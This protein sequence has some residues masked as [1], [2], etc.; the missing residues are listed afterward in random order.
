MILQHIWVNRLQFCPQLQEYQEL[1][2]KIKLTPRLWNPEIELHVLLKYLS[3]ILG[4]SFN[5]ITFKYTQT[6]YKEFQCNHK[7]NVF[8]PITNFKTHTFDFV[9]SKVFIK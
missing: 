7:K 3:W 4:I 5:L 2:E 8:F 1:I 6:W 9:N